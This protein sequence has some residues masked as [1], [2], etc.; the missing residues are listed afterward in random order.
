[1]SHA[2]K[3]M[4]NVVVRKHMNNVDVVNGPI[5][6]FRLDGERECSITSPHQK[7]DLSQ[8]NQRRTDY[9]WSLLLKQGEKLSNVCK[10]SNR[11]S[12]AQFLLIVIASSTMQQ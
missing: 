3:S 8:I 5:N 12:S 7:I 9:H 1:M 11:S 10:Y 6:I 4:R 2:Q